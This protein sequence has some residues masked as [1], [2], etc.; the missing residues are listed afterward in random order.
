MKREEV[1][2]FAKRLD[3]VLTKFKKRY[4]PKVT[5]DPSPELQDGAEREYAEADPDSHM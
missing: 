3:K 4:A 1:D 2:I 5:V